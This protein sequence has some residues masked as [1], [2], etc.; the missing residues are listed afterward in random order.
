MVKSRASFLLISGGD[1]QESYWS[2]ML[3]PNYLSFGYRQE[4]SWK[5]LKEIVPVSTASVLMI[6]GE[7][8]F[9]GVMAMFIK[10]KS[11]IIT[12][13]RLRSTR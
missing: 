7:F 4:T 2:S 3:P 6:N 8:V 9:S 12:L 1:A 11:Q 13:N 10:L 5:N